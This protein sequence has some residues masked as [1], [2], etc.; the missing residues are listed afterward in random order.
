VLLDGVD[1]YVTFPRTNTTLDLGDG[2]LTLEAWVKRPAN[3]PAA[4]MCL[5]DKGLAA[6]QFCYDADKAAFLKTAPGAT[7]PPQARP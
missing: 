6:Y 7:S 2:P 3:A 1:D 5:F 4:S